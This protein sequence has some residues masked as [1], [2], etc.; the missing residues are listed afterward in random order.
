[1]AIEGLLL[2]CLI[3][4]WSAVFYIFNSLWLQPQKIRKILRQQGIGGPPPSFLYGNVTEMENLVKQE[5][6]KGPIKHDYTPIVLPYFDKWKKEYGPVFLYTM[7]NV[8][9][10]HVAHP[11]LVRDMSLCLSLDF[12]KSTYMRK[13]QEP[14]F[15]HGI[16]K[17]NG[18][19][20][21]QQRKIIAPELF[22]DKV[23]GMVDLMVESTSTLIETWDDKIKNSKGSADIM[24]DEDLRNYSA[25]VISKACFGSSYSEGKEIFTKLRTL[26]RALSRPNLLIEIAGLRYLP[27]RRNRE[28]WRLNK[29]VRCLILKVVKDGK[30]MG[31][32]TNKG[33]LWAILHSAG[34]SENTDDF[35]VDN[36]K[37]M[38][39]AGHETVAVTAAWCL[40]LLSYHPEWQNL[41]REEVVEVC[42]K[43]LPNFNSLQ[44]MKTLSMV[45]QET[46]R[47]YPPTGFLARETLQDMN[48]GGLH[49][50]KGVNINIPIPTLHHDPSAWGPDVHKF[51]PGRFSKG[52]RSA[53]LLPYMYA[54][55]GVGRRKCV[56]QNFAITE[57]KVILSVIL[58]KFKF[59]LSP[60]YIHSPCMRLLVE[61]E[62]G[63]CLLMER[64]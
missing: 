47:L 38:Y 23:K 1:M 46:L 53:N 12:G 26:K 24:I 43:C 21:A 8:P 40:F 48:F 39:I 5:K 50:P 29:E 42:G 13:T 31:P 11:E 55:F 52:A 25:D 35:V 33:L 6:P 63:V 28:V 57:L 10:L 3:W 15:G 30:D 32:T 20:W 27:T 60:N 59:S 19:S 36:C 37:T 17:S 58:L 2:L 41:A 14:L 44:K 49:I 9:F 51:N 18:K 7:G 56:G 45:I 64:V 34:K 22:L 62:F 61:P 54:P 16:V 4:F